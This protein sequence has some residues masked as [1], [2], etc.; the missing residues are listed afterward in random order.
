M[1][2]RECASNSCHADERDDNGSCGR[3]RVGLG[4]TESG[5]T[6]GGANP[7]YSWFPSAD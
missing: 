1:P 5:W 7:K 2:S 6:E 4:F 3:P